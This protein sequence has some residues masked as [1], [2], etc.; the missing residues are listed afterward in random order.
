MRKKHRL[1]WMLWPGKAFYLRTHSAQSTW[2]RPSGA[3]LLS[4]T[5]PS[6]H[7]VNTMADSL[8]DALPTLPKL[9]RQGGFGT[10]GIS[11][12]GNISPAFGFGNGFDRF[13]ELYKMSSFK[14]KKVKCEV[15]DAELKSALGLESDEVPVM[16]SKD[17]NECL[18][19]LIPENRDEDLFIF[20]WSI[21]THDPYFH[22]DKALARFSSP[23]DE[24]LWVKQTLRMRGKKQIEQL[25]GLYQDM[26]YFNDYHLGLLIEELKNRDLFDRTLLIVTGDHGEAFGEHGVNS[27][28][29]RPYDEQIRV[30]LI[31]KLPEDRYGGTNN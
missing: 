15:D 10:I 14:E 27:H 19:P 6:V 3:S 29:G 31:M 18:F 25:K 1:I 21:D 28:A 30:P 7:G 4:S 20:V 16:T 13:V 24:V 26:I 8:P 2:T 12:M 11:A 22:R 23:S 5:Y 17:I 9:L